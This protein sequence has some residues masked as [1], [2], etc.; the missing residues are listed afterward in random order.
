[1]RLIKRLLPLVALITLML[2]FFG[3]RSQELDLSISDTGSALGTLQASITVKSEKEC[4]LDIC[5]GDENGEWLQ[6]YTP[7]K[8]VSLGENEEKTI[9]INTV[10]PPG[11]HSLLLVENGRARSLKDGKIAKLPQVCTSFGE[12]ELVFGALS[13][14]HFNKHDELGTG[15]DA[16]YLFDLA[17]DYF[18]TLDVDLVA[19]SGDLSNDGEE[20]A[21]EKFNSLISERD[22]EVLACG[23][24]HDV[25][26]ISNGIWLE[27]MSAG[28][29]ELDGVLDIA[30][31]GYDFTYCENGQDVFIFLTQT[32][33]DYRRA[34]SRLLT[35]EQIFWFRQM[36]EKYK[37]K[38]V[39]L[40]FHTFLCGPDGQGHTGVGNI[41][42]PGGYEYNLPYTYFTVDERAFRITLMEYKNITFF[43]GHSHWMFEMEKYN[44]NANFSS[45]DGEYGYMVHIPS[46]TSPRYI[47]ENDTE[48]TEMC[49]EYSQGYVIYVY[50]SC[51]VLLPYDFLAG[52]YYT[53]YMEIIYH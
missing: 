51:T 35:N 45:F 10:V 12:A 21:Y 23:G 50:D 14:V 52:T 40:F 16:L 41:R 43:S 2:C 19:I 1:M 42:N 9:E 20:S 34:E 27:H 53:E 44:E 24:N 7:V 39:Y 15:D 49:G 17:L 37:D 8:T 47:G 32:Y 5:F 38:R 30:Q 28:L 22:Y 25:K 29:S 36:A 11:A 26:A 33:W 3:C 46:V 4:E 31:N 6:S 18:D 48:R 13:D